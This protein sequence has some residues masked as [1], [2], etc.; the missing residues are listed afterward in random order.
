MPFL[1]WILFAYS[2]ILR[3]CFYYESVSIPALVSHTFWDFLFL[4]HQPV[5]F[6]CQDIQGFMGPLTVVFIQPAL[7]DFPCFVQ[8]SEQVKI[9]YFCPVRLVKPLNKPVLCRLTRLDK[10]Q[11]HT[12]VFSPLR[13]S[14]WY[15][16]GPLS[17]RI[18]SGYPR[19]ATI[20]SRTRTIRCA[21]IFRSISIARA[22]RLKSSTTLKVRKRRPQTSASC[23]KSIDQLW[24]SASGVASGG[25]LRTGRRYLPLRRKF[26]F[27]RQ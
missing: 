19:F 22:S 18:F 15:Q 23:I 8:R 24:L 12:M 14:Q 3:V 16:F 9:Q 21:G 2:H 20:L 10:F 25:G 13:Q 17:I 5:F 7:C 27:S 4:S 1:N 6:R 11:H 26:S